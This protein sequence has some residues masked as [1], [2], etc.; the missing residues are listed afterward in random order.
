MNKWEKEDDI[1]TR[2]FKS[3]SFIGGVFEAFTECKFQ[4]LDDLRETNFTCRKW[5]HK[6]T[7]RSCSESDMDDTWLIRRDGCANLPEK[8]PVL[9]GKL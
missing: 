2:L 5:G 6:E 7:E 4:D 8:L 9:C 3:L 1:K